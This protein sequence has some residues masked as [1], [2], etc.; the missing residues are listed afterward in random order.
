MSVTQVKESQYC[1]ASPF[2]RLGG[3][4]GATNIPYFRCILDSLA[5]CHLGTLTCTRAFAVEIYDFVTFF[6]LTN[7][8]SN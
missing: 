1:A 2:F 8:S 7:A 4:W 3:G 5:L 6:V